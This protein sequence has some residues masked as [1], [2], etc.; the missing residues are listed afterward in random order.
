MFIYPESR[1]GLF[2]I[3]NAAGI[4]VDRDYQLPSE[5]LGVEFWSYVEE[6]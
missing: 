2:E 3:L 4:P 5:S 6:L 1:A